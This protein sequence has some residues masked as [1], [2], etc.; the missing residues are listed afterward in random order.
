MA[1]RGPQPAP[2]RLKVLRGS[3]PSRIN[4]NEPIPPGDDP[5]LPPEAVESVRVLWEEKLAQLRYM[6]LS[7]RSDQELLYAYCVA[8]VKF[9][10]DVELLDRSDILLVNKAGEPYRNPILPALRDHAHLMLVLGREFG[11]T[12]SARSQIRMEAMANAST[13]ERRKLLS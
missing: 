13:G 10:R 11:F 5:E 12:P 1:R 4:R 9:R 3:K 8:V 7:E 6:G 2:T